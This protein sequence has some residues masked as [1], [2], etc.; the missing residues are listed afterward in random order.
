MRHEL[1]VLLVRV[2]DVLLEEPG[3]GMA[4][5]LPLFWLVTLGDM[6]Q[7]GEMNEKMFF[8]ASFNFMAA[9]SSLTIIR[10]WRNFFLFNQDSGIHTVT[11]T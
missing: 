2:E 3:D 4:F 7:S 8:L 1:I 6:L 5:V 11:F 9:E 10:H